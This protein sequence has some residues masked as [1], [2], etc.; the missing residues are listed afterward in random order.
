MASI[1]K[2][3]AS[4]RKEK[5]T[6]DFHDVRDNGVLEVA[7]VTSHANTCTLLQR[8]NHAHI[9]SSDFYRPDGIPDAQTQL[10]FVC[11]FVK[12]QQILIQF[13]EN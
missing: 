9:S 6:L 12:N 7:S 10:I 3:Q 8:D 1:P 4:S 2:Q 5:T 13:P 11:D